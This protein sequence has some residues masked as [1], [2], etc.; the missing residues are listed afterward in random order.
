MCI[1]SENNGEYDANLMLS[2]NGTDMDLSS[3]VSIIIPVFNTCVFLEETLESVIHQTY[4]NLDIII[5]DD[6]SN[7]GSDVIC[8]DYAAM[9]GRIRVIH[10]QNQGLSSARNLGLELAKGDYIAFID[11]DDAYNHDFI[12]LMIQ[13]MIYDKADIVVCRYTIHRTIQKMNSTKYEGIF[14][15]LSKTIYDNKSALHALAEFSISSA[16]WNKIY[17]RELWEDIRFPIGKVHE[18]I[19]TIFRVINKCERMSIIESPLYM[20]RKRPESITD[21]I[22]S[23]FIYDYISASSHF[24]DFIDKN[25]PTLFTLK[26][27]NIRKQSQ[28]QHLIGY[29]I[30]YLCRNTTIQSDVYHDLKIRIKQLYAK[31]EAY[32]ISI[33]YE[34]MYYAIVLFPFSLRLPFRIF[35]S[36]KYFLRDI[37]NK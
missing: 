32:N 29:T 20:Y 10:Q 6:G 36:V 14:P 26:D 12:K 1:Q 28:L 21:K 2:I 22:T 3:M 18:D 7:D 15:T 9:D 13:N 27:L 35:Y 25:I 8:D 23:Q 5:I 24:I 30:N 34:A 33:R 37:L 31:K 19:D 4:S 17:K 11:S 16:V